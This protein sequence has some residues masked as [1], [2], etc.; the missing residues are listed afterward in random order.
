M[1]HSKD[2]AFT[3]MLMLKL[4][5]CT[6][7]INNYSTLYMVHSIPLV[8]SG[9]FFSFC[10]IMIIFES[11]SFKPSIFKTT[12]LNCIFFLL[13]ITCNVHSNVRMV[14]GYVDSIFKARC[15]IL[16][17]PLKLTTTPF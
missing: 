7:L 5:R 9:P 11:E 3:F 13:F 8:W 15:G 10:R 2:L 16:M 4:S 1:H 17:T 12:K 6:I 14:T